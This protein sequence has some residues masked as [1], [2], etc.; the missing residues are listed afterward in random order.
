MSFRR[1]SDPI[2]AGHR[3]DTSFIRKPG[4]QEVKTVQTEGHFIGNSWISGFKIEFIFVPAC[5][6]GGTCHH[7]VH[8]HSH[9]ASTARQ[10]FSTQPRFLPRYAGFPP[11]L[12]LQGIA[13]LV[14]CNLELQ[15]FMNGGYCF[16]IGR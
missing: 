12:N 16:L 5:P 8:I 4:I 11:L 2:C 9:H 6:D 7:H 1:R 3:K 10:G 14:F 13:G 15:E